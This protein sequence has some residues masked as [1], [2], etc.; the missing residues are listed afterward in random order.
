M[1]APK[2]RCSGLLLYLLIKFKKSIKMTT[3]APKRYLIFLLGTYETESYSIMEHFRVQL[4]IF[5]L[6]AC[7]MENVDSTKSFS[8]YRYTICL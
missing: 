8:K 4:M 3:R 1:K 2:L 6:C 5:E 7:I